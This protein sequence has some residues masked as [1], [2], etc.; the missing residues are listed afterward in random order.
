MLNLKGNCT[1]KELKSK[2]CCDSC[3]YTQIFKEL[4]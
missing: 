1:F 3:D 4:I 2:A